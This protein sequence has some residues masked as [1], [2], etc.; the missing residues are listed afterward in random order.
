M[1]ELSQLSSQWWTRS[2]ITYF[3]LSQVRSMLSLVNQGVKKLNDMKTGAH[4]VHI[5][6]Q[7]KALRSHKCVVHKPNRKQILLHPQRNSMPARQSGL[8][9]PLMDDGLGLEEFKK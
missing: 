1:G 5:S 3:L 9:E 6:H 8:Q 4:A 2:A 7:G